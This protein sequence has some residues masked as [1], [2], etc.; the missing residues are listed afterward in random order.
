MSL[1]GRSQLAVNASALDLAYDEAEAYIRNAQEQ[2]SRSFHEL[3]CIDYSSPAI[4]PSA[5]PLQRRKSAHE[6][7]SSKQRARLPDPGKADEPPRRKRFTRKSR[8]LSLVERPQ[9]VQF[10]DGSSSDEELSDRTLQQN[11]GL[12][13]STDALSLRPIHPF[14]ERSPQ[15]RAQLPRG[16]A[17]RRAN[18]RQAQRAAS[19]E[20]PI[21][22]LYAN[23]S[24]SVRDLNGLDLD[25]NSQENVTRWA[26]QILAELD[27]LPSSRLDLTDAG[28]EDSKKR[29]Y[30]D[31]LSPLSSSVTRSPA[32]T[33]P[34]K[35]HT[36]FL[37]GDEF[38]DRV[39]NNNRGL[40]ASEMHLPTVP[41][42]FLQSSMSRLSMSLLAQQT[43]DSSND[44]TPRATPCHRSLETICSEDRSR[45]ETVETLK[46]EPMLPAGSDQPPKMSERNNNQGRSQ[47]QPTIPIRSYGLSPLRNS[48]GQDG[49]FPYETSP[50][51]RGKNSL[52]SPIEEKIARRRNPELV[53]AQKKEAAMAPSKNADGSAVTYPS[54]PNMIADWEHKSRG[55][56]T[57]RNDPGVRQYKLAAA[58]ARLQNS[59]SELSR[60][61][62]TKL[63]GKQCDVTGTSVQSSAT[64]MA[65]GHGEKDLLERWKK[66][67]ECRFRNST[68]VPDRTVNH[69]ISSL[70]EAAE[71]SRND[72]LERPPELSGAENGAQVAQDVST[73][74]SPFSLSRSS[75][76]D[77]ISS[78]NETPTNRFPP[79]KT[80]PTAP[81]PTAP[82]TAL[83]TYPA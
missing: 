14:D 80:T 60:R 35:R 39:L 28:R 23:R 1:K 77:W 49:P 11:V 45:S 32:A 26:S 37:S 15:S 67:A 9:I 18:R 4:N 62:N 54:I 83:R 10:G 71:S 22:N 8:K 79:P 5:L 57:N 48:K 38:H 82:I 21:N 65:G 41:N 59:I 7:S 31:N 63:K 72:T 46:A 13:R 78:P 74:T 24:M 44:C 27:S 19:K 50:S 17:A 76:F 53:L 61:M 12:S 3:V 55:E 6:L 66:E 40:S 68:V 33:P 81:P 47:L 70:I 30:E 51:A 34:V 56:R 52:R 36:V 25:F 42:P 75:S 64:E 20:A 69:V 73:Q 29:L 58:D 16:P 2:L 43:H